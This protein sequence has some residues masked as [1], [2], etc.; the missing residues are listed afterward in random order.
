M[1]AGPPPPPVATIPP[2]SIGLGPRRVVL[3]NGAVVT[4]KTTHKTPVVALNLSVR[5]GSADDPPGGEGTAHLLARVIDRGTTTRTADEIAELLDSR[6]TSLSVV[7]SRH[8]FS[9]VC[10]CLAE[11]FEMVLDLLAEMLM[12]PAL[13]EAEIATRKG[14][15]ITALRQ[16]EDSPSA[17][18]LE[19]VRGLLYG[20]DHP[21]GR[22]AKGSVEIVEAI[23]RSALE[24]FHT[25]H[26]APS[27]LSVVVAGD[28]AETRAVEAAGR[29]FEG[30]VVRPADHLRRRLRWSTEASAEV[31]AGRHVRADG[32][33]VPSP[34]APAARREMVIAM[35]GK[36]QVDL[37]YGF[38]AVRRADPAY[39][40]YWLMNNAL[41]QYALG[42]RLGA[43]IRERDGMAYSVGSSLDANLGE[44]PLL[45]RAGVSSANVERTLAAIDAEMRLLLDRGLTPRELRE[46]RQ[47]LIGSM[48][49]ALETNSGIANFLQTAEF[50][51]LG[52]DYDRRL[53]DLLRAVTLDDV[54]AAA[55]RTI[56]PDRASVVIAGPYRR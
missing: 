42:G 37:A 50:F 48:P 39:Y 43:T 26:V 12:A 46:S 11:D 18:A 44:G 15:V 3:P 30:W 22:R 38:T 21:Y 14:E 52:L 8:Q 25:A 27:A 13:P 49:R 31:E 51:G 45:V 53:P 36:A 47:Y 54:H 34:P 1:T 4:V 23:T 9:F 2:R 19:G 7:V 10:T 24:T 55:R 17:R 32:R 35:P 33:Q 6:G 20:A 40:A 41:G 29:A 28:V 5:T 16:D 56:N